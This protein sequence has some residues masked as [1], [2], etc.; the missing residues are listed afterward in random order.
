MRSCKK[1]PQADHNQAWHEQRQRELAIDVLGL[2]CLV[3]VAS[4]L[5]LC[6]ANPPSVVWLL[7]CD[8]EP[9]VYGLGLFGHW[10]SWSCALVDLIDCV[11]CR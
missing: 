2:L 10:H 8:Q 7:D 5:S 3:A 11:W 6:V 1:Q 4:S 9:S